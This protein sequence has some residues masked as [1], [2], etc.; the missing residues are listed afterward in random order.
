MN[1]AMIIETLTDPSLEDVRDLGLLLTECVRAGASIGFVLPLEPAEVEAY[2]KKVLG[3]LAGGYR[4][5]LVLR[6]ESAGSNGRGR[7]R[8]VGTAQLAL[9]SRAN[10]RHRAEVQ[11]VMVLPSHRRR[12]L[13][14]RLMEEIEA[15]ARRRQV[16]LLFLDTSAGR[17]GACEFY[18]TLGY[19]YAGGLPDYAL[20]PDGSSSKNAIYFKQ[21]SLPG[22][23]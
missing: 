21:L 5:I 20:D 18:A 10:G 12:G 3:D 11:K 14:A 6:E 8:I 7:R 2:W 16:R 1:S 22:V 4:V 23:A 17:G 15:I 13:A 9:E 19:T